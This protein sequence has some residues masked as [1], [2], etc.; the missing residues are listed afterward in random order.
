[1]VTMVL[2]L[3]EQLGS[4]EVITPSLQETYL[5]PNKFMLPAHSTYADISPVFIVWVLDTNTSPDLSN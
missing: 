5:V 2:L 3:P 4:S 1:M